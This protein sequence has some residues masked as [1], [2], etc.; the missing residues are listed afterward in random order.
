VSVFA[1]IVELPLIS[2]INQLEVQLVIGGFWLRV[3]P[4]SISRKTATAKAEVAGEIRA[5]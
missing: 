2:G 1:R 3:R 5:C 4:L